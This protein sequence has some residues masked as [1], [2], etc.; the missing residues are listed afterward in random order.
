MVKIHKLVVLLMVFGLSSSQQRPKTRLEILFDGFMDNMSNMA[1]RIN[2]VMFS[3]FYRPPRQRL[4]HRPINSFQPIQEIRSNDIGGFDPKNRQ[5]ADAPNTPTAHIHSDYGNRLTSH[6]R[7]QNKQQEYEV[8]VD[9][10]PPPNH[11]QNNFHSRPRPPPRGGFD[12]RTFVNR[13]MDRR[14]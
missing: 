7:D 14:K 6:Q 9:N 5:V 4:L 8:Y 3:P 10:D 12:L 1:S 13:A 2:E 11:P